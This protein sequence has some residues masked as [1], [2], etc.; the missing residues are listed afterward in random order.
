MP[1]YSSNFSLARGKHFIFSQGEWG[2]P[3]ICKNRNEMLL[4]GLGSGDP[5]S[6]GQQFGEFALPVLFSKIGFYSDWI[7]SNIKEQQPEINS[8]MATQTKLTDNFGLYQL[9]SHR[10]Q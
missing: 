6:C 1:I 9:D 2:S 8:I 4:L 7:Q 5:L 3:L 10:V